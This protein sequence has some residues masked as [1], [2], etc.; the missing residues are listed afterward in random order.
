MICHTFN[1]QI[2]FVET[3]WLHKSCL[4]IE[5]YENEQKK[6]EKPSKTKIEKKID[7]LVKLQSKDEGKITF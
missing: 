6:R 2:D 1:N 3:T 7:K 4:I 5:S